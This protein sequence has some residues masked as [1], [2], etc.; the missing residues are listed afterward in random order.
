MLTA[1]HPTPGP[2]ALAV[3]PALAVAPVRVRDRIDLDAVVRR[4]V[5]LS[6]TAPE[7][8]IIVASGS[9]SDDTLLDSVAVAAE[10]LGGELVR[11]PGSVV[12]AVNA[13]LVAAREAQIDAVLIG[14]DLELTHAG[15]LSAL[16]ARRDTRG[17]PAAIVGARLVHRTGVVAAAG[18]FFSQ[19]TRE[20]LP[21]LQYAPADLPASLAPCLCP[22]SGL[23]LIR[24]ETLAEVG[25][26]DTELS[27]EHA[28]L[29]LCLRAFG[30]DLECVLEPAAVAGRQ[31]DPAPEQPRSAEERREHDRSTWVLRDRH[32][33]TDFSL[34]TPEV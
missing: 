1:P 30:A 15:W 24:A 9:D 17:R 26:L 10:E 28:Q 14:D 32:R 31:T 20:F 13:G 5:S 19:L 27:C 11:G 6:A 23:V 33:G 8:P 25:V 34:W 7:L 29:D 22:V 12:A 3:R 16:Q 4:L 18:L 2:D 21:R